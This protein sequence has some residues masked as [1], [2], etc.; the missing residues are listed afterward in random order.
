VVKFNQTYVAVENEKKTISEKFD[1][2]S[3]RNS[4]L[5]IEIIILI[6]KIQTLEKE[7]KNYQRIYYNERTIIADRHSHQILHEHNNENVVNR[8]RVN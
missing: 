2:C 1:K 3:K 5:E 8:L 6:T 7:K 4:D